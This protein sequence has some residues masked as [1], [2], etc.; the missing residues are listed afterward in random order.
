MLRQNEANLKHINKTN[1]TIRQQMANL[2]EH[3]KILNERLPPN[4][5]ETNYSL[6][7]E[8]SYVNNTINGTGTAYDLTDLHLARQANNICHGYPAGYYPQGSSNS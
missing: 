3:R 2:Q 4:L 6:M 5:R 7:L 8:L 1:E